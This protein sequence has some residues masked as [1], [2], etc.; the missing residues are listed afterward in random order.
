MDIDSVESLYLHIPFCD[1][2]C[3]YCDFAKVIKGTFSSE[4]YIH[5][6]IQE[7][8]SYHIKDHS[9]K[10][11]YIG[12]GT[13]SC[14]EENELDILLSHLYKRFYP[15]IEFTIEVNP[16]SLTD[17]KIAILSKYKINR[18]SLGVQSANPQMLS[19]LKRN[20][21]LKQVQNVVASLKKSNIDNINLDF[22]YGIPSM[23]MKNVDDDIDFALSL[24]VKHLSFYSLQIEKGTN[25]YAK[26]LN[27]VSDETMDN[28]Y[29]HIVKRLKDNGF[30]RY[31][32]SNFAKAGSESKHNL[33][34]W[35]D[36]KYYACG[37][38]ASGYLDKKRYVNTKS[39]MTYLKNG[40]SPSYD[41]LTVEDEEI[42]FLMLNLRLKEGF[43]LKEYERRFS[44]SFREKYHDKIQKHILDFL[45]TPTSFSIQEKS[46]YIMDYLLLEL[47]S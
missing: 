10:T 16:E 39:I 30:I 5:A 45:I 11:I 47:I 15:W 14:L 13:P 31:E 29:Q 6:L 46:L 44:C 3:P 28:Q 21:T 1:S 18:V 9:L 20:H 25:F 23:T 2:L 4:D 42:E 32:I 36:N 27:P 41:P 37:V 35:K 24:D 8:E 17:G 33:N 40:P 12:G 7:I 19:S 43:L 22:I 34:Y 38:S 26:K